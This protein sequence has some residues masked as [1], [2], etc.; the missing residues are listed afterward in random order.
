MEQLNAAVDNT[1]KNTVKFHFFTGKGPIS[2]GIR[3][4]THSRFSHV[5][6]EIDG[7]IYE[8]QGGEVRASTGLFVR[9]TPCAVKTVE[10]VV[11][12][13]RVF[14]KFVKSQLGKK[15][16]YRQILSFVLGQD[17]RARDTLICSEYAEE[18]LTATGDF[19]DYDQLISPGT[20]EKMLVQTN[21]VKK[22]GR[23]YWRTKEEI[24]MG[25]RV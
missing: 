22:T 2:A 7:L 13:I 4:M 15:Y 8:A 25:G 18:A 1:A 3:W 6:I 14:E 19:P 10:F 9:N 11:A 24:E 5:A 16:G 12:D 20:F 17:K 21:R 23:S